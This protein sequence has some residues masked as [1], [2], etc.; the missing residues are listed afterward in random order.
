[1]IHGQKAPVVGRICMDQMMVDVSDID[2]VQVGDRAVLMG[3][4]GEAEITAEMLASLLGTISYEI[5][6]LV[7]PRVPRWYYRHGRLVGKKV[8]L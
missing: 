2:G 4:D 6:C 3:R 5:T 7:N 1:M 8:G